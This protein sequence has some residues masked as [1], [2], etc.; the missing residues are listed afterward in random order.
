MPLPAFTTRE[1]PEGGC[2]LRSLCA[3]SVGSSL[4][5]RLVAAEVEPVAQRVDLVVVQR[6]MVLEVGG[7]ALGQVLVERVDLPVPQRRQ[8]LRHLARRKPE[9]HQHA[10]SGSAWRTS[11]SVSRASPYLAHQVSSSTPLPCSS[12]MVLI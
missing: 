2:S 7:E 12:P 9:A 6:R 4:H 11:F 1:A 5:H 3:L 8:H 10:S